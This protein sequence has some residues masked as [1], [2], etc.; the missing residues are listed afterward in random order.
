MCVYYAYDVYM[1][2]EIFDLKT[3]LYYMYSGDYIGHF[4]FV[5]IILQ[6]YLLMPLWIKLFKI[7]NHKIMLTISLALCFFFKVDLL[8][9]PPPS[10][11]NLLL[12]IL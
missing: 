11:T 10:M 2:I 3:L 9:L 7:V 5:I 4:Y 8:I 12:T 6:F 1:G